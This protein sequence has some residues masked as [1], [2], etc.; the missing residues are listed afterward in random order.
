MRDKQMNPDYWSFYLA[1]AQES[2][3]LFAPLIDDPTKTPKHRLALAYSTFGEAYNRL[4]ASYSAGYPKGELAARYSDVVRHR[5][6]FIAKGRELESYALQE[7]AG[8]YDRTYAL[9][10]LAILLDVP[11]EISDALIDSLDFFPDRDSVWEIFISDLGR[12]GRP[13]APGLVWP[14][15]Y[16]TL[17]AA[18]LGPAPSNA[19]SLC[20][21]V[22]GWYAAM[23]CTPW[24]DSHRSA[25]N[26]YYGYWCF[27]AA[28]AA[29]IC[30]IDDTDIRRHPHYPDDLVHG[31]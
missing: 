10:A 22:N 13:Q 28:A 25:H 9:L 12:T 27:E 21:F 4:I 18:M 5:A 26:T 15:A 29:K 20:Q 30:G 17:L 7:Y 3:D 6:A 16:R 14:D 19:A 31:G 23:N 11:R 24:H 1:N 2:I 8:G